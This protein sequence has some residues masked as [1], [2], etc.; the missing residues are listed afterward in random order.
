M[1]VMKRSTSLELYEFL[2]LYNMAF[3]LSFSELVHA[4]QEEW[5]V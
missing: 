4:M 1:L 5:Q 3:G 2:L